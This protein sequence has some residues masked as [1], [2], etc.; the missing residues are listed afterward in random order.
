MFPQSQ[1]GLQNFVQ[2]SPDSVQNTQK[3]SFIKINGE[4]DQVSQNN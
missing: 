3:R 2:D 4:Q 1:N